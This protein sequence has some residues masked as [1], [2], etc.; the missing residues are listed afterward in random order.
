MQKYFGM[1]YPNT[2]LP[3]DWVK[4]AALY[5]DKIGRIEWP[6]GG[7][8]SDSDVVRQLR[9]EIGF[10]VNLAPS[11]EDLAIV[12]NLLTNMLSK[13]H[14][15]IIKHYSI[16]SLI[17]I[18]GTGL[19]PKFNLIAQDFVTFDLFSSILN[20]DLGQLVNILNPK[21]GQV[22]LQEDIGILEFRDLN[23]LDKIDYRALNVHQGMYFFYMK[24]LAEQMATARHLHLITDNVFSIM[25]LSA[26][27]RWNGL[28]RQY[29][30][31]MICSHI[32]L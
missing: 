27:I 15:E 28:R 14:E 26:A 25:L 13:N 23:T 32:L 7:W 20:S 19:F 30:S 24:M 31:L 5:W 6:I 11:S 3:D 4:L 12:S 17:K 1:Y 9:D 8:G 21:S 10:I 2:I 22:V 16:S 29:S 18:Y